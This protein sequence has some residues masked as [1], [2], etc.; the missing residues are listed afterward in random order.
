[1][2]PVCIQQ[3]RAQCVSRC[4][5]RLFPS[6]RA[7][8]RAQAQGALGLRPRVP[9]ASAF[10]RPPECPQC[11]HRVR[12]GWPGRA[13]WDYSACRVSIMYPA[14]IQLVSSLYPMGAFAMW[15]PRA[16]EPTSGLRATAQCFRRTLGVEATTC[17]QFISSLY[18]ACIQTAPRARPGRFQH[19]LQQLIQC[20][21]SLY[22][23]FPGRI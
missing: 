17:I 8:A 11:E 4:C 16:S 6:L 10:L 23:A 15:R 12:R 5:R 2:L 19:L 7:A 1:M 22:P 9:K 21:P 20:I 3:E 18:P 14:R 13:D